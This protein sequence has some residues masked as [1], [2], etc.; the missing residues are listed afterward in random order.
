MNPRE[1]D[2]DR[3]LFL[4]R[5][6]LGATAKQVALLLNCEDERP[7][8]DIPSYKTVIN[9]ISGLHTKGHLDKTIYGFEEIGR[10]GF[11]HLSR[12][13]MI[14]LK[15]DMGEITWLED[16]ITRSKLQGARSIQRLL[17]INDMR[18]DLCALMCSNP[19]LSLNRWHWR[20]ELVR[21]WL[22]KTKLPIPQSIHG[23][24]DGFCAVEYQGKLFNCVL[25]VESWGAGFG[26]NLERLAE[27]FGAYLDGHFGDRKSEDMPM[28]L[29]IAEDEEAQC[30]VYD[31]V[32]CRLVDEKLSEFVTDE[33]SEHPFVLK[34]RFSER[35]HLDI[36][37]SRKGNFCSDVSQAWTRIL[38]ADAAD[39]NPYC[40]Q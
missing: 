25:I 20:S 15:L 27:I 35:N 12:E 32:F 9:H 22:S 4:F 16:E 5:R 19:D 39:Y 34:W 40:S 36:G 33:G 3:L 37:A 30:R 18:L 13:G 26:E 8:S 6:V 7:E 2:D 1:V 21:P 28:F 11:Y 38:L 29:F 24:V 10:A 14:Y 17:T 31:E 23:P